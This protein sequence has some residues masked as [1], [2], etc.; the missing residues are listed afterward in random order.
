MRVILLH[1]YDFISSVISDIFIAL[2]QVHC[3]SEALPTTELIHLK[4]LHA[5]T[6]E[7]LD[8]GPC[9]AARVG[10]DPAPLWTQGTE[11]NT[12]PQCP[13]LYMTS[14]PFSIVLQNPSKI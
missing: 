11:L 14:L 13:H 6:S 3:Y 2:R 5:T 9:A 7:G 8:Q 1:T 10:F 12:E 4:A